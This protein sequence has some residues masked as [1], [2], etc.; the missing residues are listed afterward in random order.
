M[1]THFLNPVP[2]LSCLAINRVTCNGRR[3]RFLEWM[4][5]GMDHL[6]EGVLS[7]LATN[8]GKIVIKQ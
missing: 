6:E 3:R 8:V 7:I 2:F 1:V 5:N 4:D